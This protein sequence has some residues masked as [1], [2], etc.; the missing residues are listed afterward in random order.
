MAR[1]P[2]PVDD[3]VLQV[4]EHGEAVV[5]PVPALHRA[6]Q[7]YRAP[8]LDHDVP[9]LRVVDA[10]LG[11]CNGKWGVIELSLLLF[12]NLDIFSDQMQKAFH[13][14]HMIHYG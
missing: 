14:G 4:P 6:V 5:G 8:A 11:L 1:L 7:L 12:N 2:H 9:A 10:G 3:P 13:F